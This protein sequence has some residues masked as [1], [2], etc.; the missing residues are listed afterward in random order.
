MKFKIGIL[1][2]SCAGDTSKD[3]FVAVMIIT[4]FPLVERPCARSPTQDPPNHAIRL[5]LFCF[6]LN[7]TQYFVTEDR[8][9]RWGREMKLDY[10]PFIPRRL[11]PL[12]LSQQPNPP[13][14]S[15]LPSLFNSRH[16]CL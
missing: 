15:S 2:G 14:T 12:V 16:A 5:L 13:H 11:H 8:E 1:H 6:D 3:D 4:T 10:P 7:T 9:G